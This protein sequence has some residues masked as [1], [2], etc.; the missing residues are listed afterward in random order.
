M[1]IAQIPPLFE[2]CPPALYGGTERVVAYLCD[3]L[4]ALGHAVTLFSSRCSQTRA[5]LVPVREQ[6]LRLDPALLKSDVAAHLSMLD[7][8]RS[9]AA[10]F[11]ILH[12]HTDLLHFP[13]FEHLAHKTLT[14]LHGRLDL[15]DLE[16]AYRRWHRFGLISISYSQ[17]KPLRTAHWIANVPHGIPRTLCHLTP[18]VGQRYLAYLG[19]IAPEKRPHLAVKLALRAGQ[20]LKLAAKVDVADTAY[21]RKHVE[22]LLDRPGIE[23]IGEIGDSQKSSFLGGALALLFPIDWPEPFGLVMIEAMACGTPVIAWN[24]GSVP[25]VIEDGVTGFIVESEAEALAAIQQV[26]KLD[27]R[28]I[29]ARFEQRFG[30]DI[31]ALNYSDVYTRLLSSTRLTTLRPLE[32]IAS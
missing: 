16:G 15:T 31:M 17:R 18:Y 22:P 28:L 29:R 19:R 32:T 2:A 30:A 20:P 21:F 1:R 14:T 25:E 5:T 24:R 3:E 26:A 10:E 9:R 6:P 7:E 27:R 12:F 13:L 23:F 4:V 11:D 8:V